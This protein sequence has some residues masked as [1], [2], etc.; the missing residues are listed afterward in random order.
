M[1]FLVEGASEARSLINYDCVLS[2][3]PVECHHC[4]I[5]YT[6]E[7]MADG[8]LYDLQ[9]GKTSAEGIRFGK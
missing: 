6:A 9:F 4:R 7:K 2:G 8:T 1:E 3:N 5:S